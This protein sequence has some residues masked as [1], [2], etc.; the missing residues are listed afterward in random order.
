MKINHQLKLIYKQIQLCLLNNHLKHFKFNINYIFLIMI[1]YFLTII[2][3]LHFQEL[4]IKIYF[5]KFGEKQ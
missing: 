5:K 4:T 2:G 3:I 1:K